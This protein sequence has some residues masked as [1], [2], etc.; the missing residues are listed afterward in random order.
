MRSNKL[1][2][3]ALTLLLA[4]TH[5]GAWTGAHSQPAT[6]PKPAIQQLAALEFPWGMAYLPD[7]RL[8]I[9]EKPG[10]LRIYEGRLDIR[11]S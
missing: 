9:T 2:Y 1:V 8:L 5:T 11:R 3:T 4:V 7:G 10:R 6:A